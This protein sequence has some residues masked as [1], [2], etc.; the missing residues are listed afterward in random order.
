MDENNPYRKELM[1]RAYVRIARWIYDTGITFNVVNNESFA[2]MIE[3]IG[4]FGP[5][6][7][8]PSYHMIQIPYLKKEV[9]HVHKLMK[10]HKE[11]WAKYGCSIM[12]DG[13]TDR[14]HRILIN[15]LVNCP[16][17]T[18]FL[19]SI[20]ASSYSKD[21]NKIF[22][23]LDK[24][25]DKIGEANVVQIVTDSAAANVLAGKFLEAKRPHLYSTPCAT[26]CLDLML[27]DIFKLPNFKKTFERAIG[28]LST[29][30]Q[31]GE[32]VYFGVDQKQMG[33]GAAGMVD[34]EEKP[35]MGYI[36]E[37]MDRAKKAI[38][39]AFDGKEEKYKEIFEI[40]DQRWDIQLHC[41]LHAAGFYLNLSL[42]YKDSNVAKDKEIMTGLYQYKE[43]QGYQLIWWISFSHETPDLQKF[44][45]KVLSLTC[46]SFGCERNWS[47]FE[48]L[49]SKKRNRLAQKRLNDL[50]FV[51]YNR[52]L[53]RRYMKRANIDP[54]SLKDIDESNEWLIGR[55]ENELVFD[56]DSLEWDDVVVA[57]RVE[58]SNQ[59]TRSSTTRTTHQQ[60]V[61]EEDEWE[62]EDEAE[63]EDVDGYKS[64]D[65]D[66]GGDEV[67]H[68]DD[69]VY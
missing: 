39:N 28:T 16:R 41:P 55:M 29:K 65:D 12:C 3:V 5:G 4:Q 69:D 61:D 48:H 47:V 52:A 68:V 23:L 40:I 8:P 62:D 64:N 17:G 26:H 63:E 24:F 36:Y 45:I 22:N 59:R 37:A 31:L 21:A 44:A 46:S 53:K 35:P 7:K 58:E 32:D 2:P 13:W 6:L 10:K 34:G 43:V 50:V 25:V 19:E 56:D 9:D 49:H 20:D 27:E 67:L 15:F 54:I 11:D 14:K 1:Q 18:M 30:E 38:A 66:D 51:K 33:E 60:L 57:A 42:F